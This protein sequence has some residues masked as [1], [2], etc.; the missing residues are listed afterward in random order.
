VDRHP[1]RLINDQEV[2]ILIENIEWDSLRQQG[3][4]G[5]GQGNLY[6]ITDIKLQSGFSRVVINRDQPISNKTL[7]LGPGKLRALFSSIPIKTYPRL[8]SDKA[9]YSTQHSSFN[10]TA[11]FHSVYQLI[12][13]IGKWRG[14]LAGLYSVLSLG[15]FVKPLACVDSPQI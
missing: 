2:I 12:P 11:C 4:G 8:A 9:K 3:V 1:N 5:R 6:P 14:R 7:G 10:K 15:G 13:G